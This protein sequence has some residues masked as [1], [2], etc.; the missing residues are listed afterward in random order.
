MLL[1]YSALDLDPDAR[2]DIFR[3]FDTSTD[4]KLTRVEFVSLCIRELWNVPEDQLRLAVR[5]RGSHAPALP[6]HSL[7]RESHWLQRVVPRSLIT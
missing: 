1:A 5:S 4:G 3:K 2:S 7:L 6:M